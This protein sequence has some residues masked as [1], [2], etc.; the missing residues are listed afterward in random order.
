MERDAI[1]LSRT[2]KG[3]RC[4]TDRG[5]N[6]EDCGQD[7]ASALHG[8]NVRHNRCAKAER[9]GAF[10]RP[11]RWYCW[12]AGATRRDTY[13]GANSHSWSSLA[14]PNDSCLK[15][16]DVWAGAIPTNLWC[17][18]ISIALT[19]NPL[20]GRGVPHQSS[21]LDNTARNRAI[22]SW[23]YNSNLVP[24]KNTPHRKAG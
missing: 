13:A 22:L 24:A 18:S 7:A 21:L 6:R 19:E 4:R 3:V 16:N 14:R 20:V 5:G 10:A 23:I 2:I 8:H 15:V 12:A 11:S 17:P 9:S 1:W